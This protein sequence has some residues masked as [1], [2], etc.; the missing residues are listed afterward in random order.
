M[1][2]GV[3]IVFR[4]AENRPDRYATPIFK[5]E[6]MPVAA[7]A[8]VKR[9][10]ALLDKSPPDLSRLPHIALSKNNSGW[11]TWEDW[12]NR[13]GIAVPGATSRH[14]DNYIYALE[15]AANG[16][17]LV[18]AWRWFADAYLASG[19]L[20]PLGY[21]WASSSASLYGVL[22]EGATAKPIAR[23]FIAKLAETVSKQ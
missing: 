12:F 1:G 20:I 4:Y 3:D 19:R 13:Q 23:K 2:T 10:R 11:A 14:F 16:E 21:G 22:T 18:L 9:H 15:A 17:G 5:E 8:F 7:P 6:L